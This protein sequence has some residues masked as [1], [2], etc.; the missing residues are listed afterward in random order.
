MLTGSSTT[1]PH[2]E[3]Y[4]SELRVYQFVTDFRDLHVYKA[5][6]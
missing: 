4:F 3:Y 1:R 2:G 5:V 6:R